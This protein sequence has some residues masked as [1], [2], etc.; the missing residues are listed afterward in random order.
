MPKTEKKEKA[1]LFVLEK[2]FELGTMPFEVFDAM[3]TNGGFGRRTLGSALSGVRK[4][5]YVRTAR[6]SRKAHPAL[7]L[8]PKG[9]LRVLFERCKFFSS[10]QKNTWD[11]KWRMLIF[12]IPEKQRRYRDF[13]RR[14]LASFGFFKLHKSVWVTPHRISPDLIRLLW[15][16]RIK[17]Y[18]RCIVAEHIDY[19]RDLLE[20]FQ[21]SSDDV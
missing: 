18:T 7:V 17:V 20:K 1:F 5:G 19:D 16:L 14:H 2:I 10:K 21:L 9:I 13:L 4:R 12:D 6:K 8:T 15:E 11:K 3:T